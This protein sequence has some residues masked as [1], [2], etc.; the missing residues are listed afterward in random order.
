MTEVTL[1][2]GEKDAL[3]NSWMEVPNP[4]DVES[5]QA[6]LDPVP[7]IYHGKSAKE[8]TALMHLRQDW[9]DHHLPPQYQAEM[10]L[11]DHD[12]CVNSRRLE[13]KDIRSLRVYT[14]NRGEKVR[15][16]LTTAVSP[17]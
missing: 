4:T 7:P 16:W 6:I 11:P 15:W 13:K 14:T 12:A 1:S 8:M 2:A 3:L 10:T 9:M 17:E 5:L